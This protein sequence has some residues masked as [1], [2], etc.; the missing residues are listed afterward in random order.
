MASSLPQTTG[1]GDI[2]SNFISF[3]QQLNNQTTGQQ[4]TNANQANTY[5]GAQQTA[6]GQAGQAYSNLL[7]GNVPQSLTE[8]S[9]LISAYTNQ[10]NQ[11]VAP[12]V[13][14]Q[15]GNGSPQNAAQY[16]MGL[17]NML[18]NQYNTGVSQYG[19]AAA[20]ASAYGL[21]P[22]GQTQAGNAS[23][24]GTTD[25]NVNGQQANGFGGGLISILASLFGL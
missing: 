5:T 18:A 14:A 13:A 25:Q 9:Q 11:N 21:T 22:T 12:Q 17:Q 1:N 6:Q 2:L 19:S 15:F 23:T 7:N 10:Y 4:S 20:G 3:M 24:L 16:S 8:P